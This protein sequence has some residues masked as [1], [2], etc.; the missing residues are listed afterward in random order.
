MET[1]DYEIVDLL[2]VQMKK[3]IEIKR[4]LYRRFTFCL[5]YMIKSFPK[6]ICETEPLT[7]AIVVKENFH[8][9]FPAATMFYNA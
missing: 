1:I 5:C 2:R 9:P 8:C 7:K 3:N 4:M 6:G